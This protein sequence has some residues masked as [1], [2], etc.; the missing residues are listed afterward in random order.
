[1]LHPLPFDAK[2]LDGFAASSDHLQP[3]CGNPFFN[4]NALAELLGDF[5]SLPAKL[6]ASFACESRQGRHGEL[7]WRD[8]DL[9]TSQRSGPL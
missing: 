7:R 9:Y 3:R 2:P 4:F 6:L 1:L 8:R 5:L